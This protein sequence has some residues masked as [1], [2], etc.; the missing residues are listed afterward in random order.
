[1]TWRQFRATILAGVLTPIVIAAVVFGL[2]LTIGGS[3]PL[4]VLFFQCFGYSSS[5]CF[6]E[7]TLT[8]AS[9]ATIVLPVVLGLFV[10]V[11]VFSRDIERGTHV[12]GL[13]QSVSRRRWYWTRVLVVFVPVVLA[14]AVLGVVFFWARYQSFSGAFTFAGVID[15]RLQFPVFGSVGLAPA[16]YTALG[17]TI[18]S[19]T[20]LLLR[21]TVGAMI[22]TLVLT[23]LAL[24]LFPVQI[25]EHYATP[26][27]HELPLE[28]I[29]NGAYSSYSQLGYEDFYPEWSVG[30]DYVDAAG[31]RVVV[32]PD[33]CISSAGDWIEP[34]PD[35]TNAEYEAR[36]DARYA[37]DAALR[38][39]CLRAAG[40][41]HYESLYHSDRLFWRFQFTEVALCL[42]LS[43]VLAGSSAMLVRRLR[44]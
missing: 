16:G 12:L 23:V 38:A 4:G 39:D 37:E 26:Q 22:A 5:Q 34:G 29:F 15:S 28:D 3:R 44:P 11:T 31:E 2:T 19:T 8:L 20:A 7:S 40:V 10:G 1:M 18:G 42:L 36:L 6:A 9:M 21:H 43:A 33:A 30:A 17:L 35:E 32:A 41:D 24:V 14:M 25:R 13:T 27:V